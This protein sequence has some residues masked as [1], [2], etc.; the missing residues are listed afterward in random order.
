MGLAE[1]MT[2]IEVAT[3]RRLAEANMLAAKNIQANG[4]WDLKKKSQVRAF[5]CPSFGE[6]EVRPWEGMVNMT[7]AMLAR[8]TALA[9]DCAD[10]D[11]AVVAPGS[12]LANELKVFELFSGKS[13]KA[14]RLML[15]TKGDDSKKAGRGF[16]SAGDVGSFALGAKKSLK[17]IGKKDLM[18]GTGSTHSGAMKGAYLGS[19]LGTARERPSGEG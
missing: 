18:N 16:M 4:Q 10:G 2:A 9:S 11:V 17:I 3:T 19:G 7:Q 14:H 5:S 13:L 1:K 12:N 8:V 15:L 6:A